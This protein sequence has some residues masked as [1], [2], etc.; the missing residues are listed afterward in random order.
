[1]EWWIR[2]CLGLPARP[3]DVGEL[4]LALPEL[5]I[6]GQDRCPLDDHVLLPWWLYP[7]D[8]VLKV[9]DLRDWV[10]SAEIPN[11]SAFV[12]PEY[13]PAKECPLRDTHHPAI[14]GDVAVLHLMVAGGVHKP[15]KQEFLNL[16]RKV[17]K[18]KIIREVI[19]TDP[20]IYLDI[21]EEG[22]VGGYDAVIDY[23]G[24]LGLDRDSQFKLKLNPSPKK[25]TKKARKLLCRK[26]KS[27]FIKINIS[28]FNQ[29]NKFHDRFYLARDDSNRMAGVFGP[30][31]NGLATKSIV[32]MGELE[33]EALKRIDQL[34]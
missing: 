24:A 14:V 13:C 16:V 12:S 10:R 22:D 5:F 4:T 15:P 7:A 25:A 26:L 27:S 23:L 20:Y 30:S 8:R 18:G 2:F 1:M 32:L 6:F 17:H 29:G 9:R 34:I 19:L 11:E 31:L 28:N 33:E 21:G 3:Q